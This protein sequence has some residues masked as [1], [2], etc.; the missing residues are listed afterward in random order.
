MRPGQKC[1]GN[2]GKWPGEHYRGCCFNEAGAE[3]PR[4]PRYALDHLILI[5]F[6]FNEA[7]AEMP[8]KPETEETMKGVKTT[9]Q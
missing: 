1:P 5:T 9:L 4:K 6:R 8:R 3:M 7:G 2:R